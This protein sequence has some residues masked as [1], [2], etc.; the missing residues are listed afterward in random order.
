MLVAIVAKAWL[1]FAPSDVSVLVT[2]KKCE[3]ELA[4]D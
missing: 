4:Q 3:V 2:E 1:S